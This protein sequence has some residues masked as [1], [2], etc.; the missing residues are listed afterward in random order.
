MKTRHRIALLFVTLI[1]GYTV[2]AAD[3]ESVASPNVARHPNELRSVAA[4]G[5]ND[6]WAVGAVA[7]GIKNQFGE[8]ESRAPMRA[9][10]VQARA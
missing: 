4:V 3:W 7:Q 9:L 8:F 10:L 2:R 5:D 6:V 1:A